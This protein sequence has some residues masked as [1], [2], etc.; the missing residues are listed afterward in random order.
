MKTKIVISTLIVL[1]AFIVSCAYT[2]L[3]QSTKPDIKAGD[4]F[5]IHTT[6]ESAPIIL[7]RDNTTNEVAEITPV[8]EEA[9]VTNW[10]T[11]DCTNE[12]VAGLFDSNGNWLNDT[13]IPVT[14]TNTV[15]DI[16]I[17]YSNS[18]I[19]SV[20]VFIGGIL[21]IA[22]GVSVLT[23]LM[24]QY[25]FKPADERKKIYEGHTNA[26]YVMLANPLVNALPPIEVE[27]L[28]PTF[29]TT[30]KKKNKKGKK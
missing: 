29:T 15:V 1:A 4:T 12:A 13:Y 23:F 14:I 11:A 21:L 9:A 6:N 2:P 10:N 19:P 26:E 17:K 5:I 27:T 16:P 3:K 24:A 20:Y 8:A 18:P 28:N 7:I 25:V 30:G 22:F